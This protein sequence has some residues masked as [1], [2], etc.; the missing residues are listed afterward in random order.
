MVSVAPSIDSGDAITLERA[1][2]SGRR[3][4]QIGED[5]VYTTTDLTDN[6]LAD[7]EQLGVVAEADVRFPALC[8]GSR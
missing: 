5:L 2:P 1:S 8:R 6:A 7:V 4:S 3:A